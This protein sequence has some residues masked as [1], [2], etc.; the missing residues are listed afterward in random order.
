M[1]SSTTFM[2][3]TVLAAVAVSAAPYPAIY[4]R[5][6]GDGT[7]KDLTAQENRLQRLKGADKR[8]QGKEADLQK[9]INTDLKNGASAAKIG[10]EEIRLNNLKNKDARIQKT[11]QRVQ[12]NI[13]TDVKKLGTRDL[14]FELEARAPGDG[15]VKD[16]TAQENRLQRLKG[17]DKRIQGKEADLQK[18][19]NTDLKNGASAAKIGAE[20]IRLNNLKNKDARIQK[21]EQRVQNNIKTDVKKLGTRDLDFELEARA[22]GDGTVKDLTAQENRLQ[23]LKGADKR[24]QGKEAGLQKQINADLKNGASAAKIGAEEIRLNNLK[25]KDARIQKT[26]QRVQNNIKTDVKKLG[27]RDLDFELEARAPGDGTVKDLTAQ[28]NRLQRLKGADKR[29]QGKEAGLQKQIN[30]DLKN[31][32]SAAKIG[33]EEIRLNNL[34][35]KD[36]RI[37]KTEQRVQNN[38]KTDVKKLGTRDL[39]LVLEARD[40]L[41]LIEERDLWDHLEQLD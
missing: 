6:P 33:A 39:H 28:E 12:N 19:I 31:G 17:A 30:T 29:I 40:L 8:I 37:Q 18:Q 4:A 38:I 13:K 26:E 5:A 22:P 11:E 3:M 10:A 41:E 35:N 7:V 20:E 34:K 25:N 27:T 23:R 1:R 36:A 2:T 32:A 14:D 15:T 21:T 16:L 9:Q 24:I